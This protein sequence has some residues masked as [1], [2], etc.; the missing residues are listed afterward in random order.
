MG[1]KDEDYRSTISISLTIRRRESLCRIEDF[2]IMKKQQFLVRIW[3]H[4]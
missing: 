1:E 3:G 2:K 4:Q